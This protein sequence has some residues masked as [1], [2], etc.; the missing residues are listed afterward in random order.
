MR[1]CIR[2]GFGDVRWHRVCVGRFGEHYYALRLKLRD[3][4]HK[5]LCLAVSIQ[6]PAILRNQN[7][8][9]SMA[10]QVTCRPVLD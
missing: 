5:S 1:I 3:M 7:A 6:H 10:T 9:M 4:P 2:F 8:L